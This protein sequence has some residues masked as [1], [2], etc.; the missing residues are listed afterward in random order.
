[1]DRNV[2]IVTQ[3]RIGS[4]RFPFKILKSIGEDSLLSI[5][6]KRIKKSVHAS[7]TIVATTF[8]DG[9]EDIIRIA[10]REGAI[11]Y[12]GSTEDVLDRYYNAAK[13]HTP[14][15]IVRLTSDCP[16][17]DAALVDEI[18][19]MAFSSD[20]DY[21]TNTLKEAF[22]DGQDVEVIRWSALERAWLEARPGSEREH[23]TPFIRK[24]S[25]FS[26]GKLF[27]AGNLSP[28]RDFGKVRM[29]VD[30]PSDLEAIRV[31]IDQLGTSRN[32]WEYAEY[33]QSNSGKFFNQR[34]LRN[35]GYLKSVQKDSDN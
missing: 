18:I 26:G 6:L 20:L 25:D 24:N 2:I 34:I 4:T 8:E 30:E 15:Y 29:T 17:I 9:V 11:P 23:V 7:K 12:Q 14:Y 35:E 10:K 19:E 27:R 31:L 13:T 22:P 3:A 28:T 16:L 33:I 1:M 21:C 32:W 5:H